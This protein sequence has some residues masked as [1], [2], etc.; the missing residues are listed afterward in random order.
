MSPGVGYGFQLYLHY[1]WITPSVPNRFG[2][3][4][5]QVFTVQPS[6]IHTSG[7]LVTLTGS[8]FGTLPCSWSNFYSVTLAGSAVQPAPA[9]YL[10]SRQFAYMYPVSVSC[11]VLTWSDSNITCTAP[12]SVDML[13]SVVVS[14]GRQSAAIS[15]TFETPNVTDVTL[16]SQT[17]PSTAGG[18]AIVVYGSGFG[19]ATWPVA[20][21]I[22][23]Q[24]ATIQSHTNAVIF[25]T[26]PAGAGS[27]V[28]L[29]VH[30]P[31]RASNIVNTISYGPPRVSNISTPQGRPCS[32]QFDL[33]VHGEVRVC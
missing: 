1:Q 16:V 12:P 22:G 28:P 5:P 24:A 17:L 30:T 20:V 14:T 31:Q 18:D 7:G 26:M 8:S 33:I 4:L 15:L 13:S 25:A 27:S 3:D 10:D 29:R 6:L 21:V 11:T 19:D 32:G 2:F 23:D 9:F